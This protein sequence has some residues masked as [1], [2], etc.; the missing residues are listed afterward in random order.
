MTE[1]FVFSPTPGEAGDDP[2]LAPELSADAKIDLEE[3]ERVRYRG[4]HAVEITAE[5]NGR[6][7]SV[8]KLA[9]PAEVLITTRRIAYVWRDVLSDPL[10]GSFYERRIMARVLERELGKIVFA[11][12]VRHQWVAAVAAGKP[13]GLTTK[14]S[15]LQINMQHGD[16]VHYLLVAG[17]TPAKALDVARVLAADVADGRLAGRRDLG[18]E[19]EDVLRALAGQKARPRALDWGSA[20]HLPGGMKVSFDYPSADSRGSAQAARDGPAHVARQRAAASL[21]LEDQ[22][23]VTSPHR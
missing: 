4:R 15:R 23:S 10:A 11:G 9:K 20:Y 22:G 14:T 13:T 16:A 17:L 5:L 2:F 19:Q 18:P 12:H 7:T 3:S 21:L 8:F 6:I 1:P